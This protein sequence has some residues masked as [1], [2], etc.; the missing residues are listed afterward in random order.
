M[1]I[2]TYR[3]YVVKP[4]LFNQFLL[5]DMNNNLVLQNTIYKTGLYEYNAVLKLGIKY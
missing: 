1:Q 3:I 5:F 2:S 4:G